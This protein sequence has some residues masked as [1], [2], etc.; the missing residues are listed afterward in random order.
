MEKDLWKALEDVLDP[1][2]PVSVVDLGLI[3]GVSFEEGKAK[4][5]LTFTSLGCPCVDIIKEAIQT[6]LSQIPGVM[7][8]EIEEVFEPWTAKDISEKGKRI[9]LS[10]G[11]V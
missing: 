11:T 9:L 8:V 5:R 6:R 2:Y 1:E 3:R 10:L 7:D 4:I